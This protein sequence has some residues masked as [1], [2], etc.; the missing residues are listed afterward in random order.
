MSFFV[1]LAFR[2]KFF[3]ISKNTFLAGAGQTV[4]GP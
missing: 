2:K 1:R 4:S 3:S